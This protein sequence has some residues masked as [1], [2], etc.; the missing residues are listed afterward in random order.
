MTPTINVAIYA[1][2]STA[3]QDCT[4]Q[5]EELRRYAAARGWAITE[6]YV[7][8]GVSGAKVTRPALD[9]LM[10][11]A[12]GARFAAVLVH[13]L[14][15]FGRSTAH[16]VASITELRDLGVRFLATSQ[17]IDTD[18]NNPISRFIIT[19]LAAFAELEREMIRERTALGREHAM[20]RGVVFGRKR[21][22]IDRQR[23]LD[24]HQAGASVREIATA[25]GIGSA[26]AHR[27]LKA[28]RAQ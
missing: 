7:D 24:M 23:A 26:T 27:L 21:L 4:I 12:R 6:E 2:V 16:C 28:P 22:V 1:R 5:L 19:L 3:D 11:D 10:R 20:K 13:K 9:R 15:R 14:D 18:V 17:G 8:H 25:L